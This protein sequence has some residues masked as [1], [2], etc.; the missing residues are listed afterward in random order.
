MNLG[1]K[2]DSRNTTV[3]TPGICCAHPFTPSTEFAVPPILA[4]P[5]FTRPHLQSRAEL[6][7]ENQRLRSLVSS[8][9]IHCQMVKLEDKRK[10]TTRSEETDVEHECAMVDFRGGAATVG[11]TAR[12]GVLLRFLVDL[13]KILFL[14]QQMLIFTLYLPLCSILICHSFDHSS[15]SYSPV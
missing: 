2:P 14:V 10:G 3:H 12:L 7:E 9:G 13:L 15:N 11:G 1:L 6:I 4:H 8:Y 5:I